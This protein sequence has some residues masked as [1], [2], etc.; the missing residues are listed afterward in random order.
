MKINVSTETCDL[1][2]SQLEKKGKKY[3][4]LNMAG[5]GWGGPAFSIVLEEQIK[6]DDASCEI[7]G[8][9]FIV[10]N[11]FEGFLDDCTV[12]HSKG[13]FGTTFKVSSKLCNS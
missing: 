5:F 3:V 10:N 4:R 9:T 13:M 7:N 6:N 8:V 2:K 12:S 1:L 11:E